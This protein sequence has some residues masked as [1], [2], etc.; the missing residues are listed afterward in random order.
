M[1]THLPIEFPLPLPG[2]LAPECCLAGSNSQLAARAVILVEPGQQ[3]TLIGH[4]PTAPVP[5]KAGCAGTLNAM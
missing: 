5:G 4:V 3:G 1:G 2:L